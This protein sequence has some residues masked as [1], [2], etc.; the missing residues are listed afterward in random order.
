MTNK[1]PIIVDGVDVSGC[2]LYGNRRCNNACNPLNCLFCSDKPNCHY[3]Q[4]AR[5]T[6]E[7]KELK[8]DYTELEQR[9]NEAFKDFQSIRQEC[10][11]L[12]NKMADVIYAATGG[13]L[14]YSNYTLDAIEQAFNDQLEILSDQK[15]EEEIKE[16]NQKLYLA[17]NEVRSKTEYIQEQREEIK[18]LEQKIE[19]LEKGLDLYKTWYRAKHDDIKNYLGRCYN[20][21]EEIREIIASQDVRT[22]PKLYDFEQ[23]NKILD[24]ISKV[25]MP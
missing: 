8:E 19:A 18:H 15:V 9:H 16:L 2:T 23:D 24:I 22:R 10:E 5:K 20:A 11:E 1:E 6:Q 7:Y 4:L 13:R 25:R 17:Q 21:L 3:K 14:S 12:K